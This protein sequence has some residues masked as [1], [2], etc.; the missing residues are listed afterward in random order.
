M[1]N[2]GSSLEDMTDEEIHSTIKLNKRT[3]YSGETLKRLLITPHAKYHEIFYFLS[4]SNRT[5]QYDSYLESYLHKNR[6][7][8]DDEALCYISEGIRLQVEAGYVDF[9]LI[10]HHF[11]TEKAFNE[12]NAQMLLIY[13]MEIGCY[14]IRE[15]L[16]TQNIIERVGRMRGDT[17]ETRKFM[18]KF[19]AALI[20]MNN[21]II[22]EYVLANEVVF[23][24]K[25]KEK[26]LWFIEGVAANSVLKDHVQLDIA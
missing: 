2:F 14:K 18:A 10:I 21:K 6:D 17:F 1:E 24:L 25:I 7:N 16:I 13:L 19:V 9:Y 22:V 23:K 4:V 26:I 8:F 5:I 20:A 12:P 11:Y 3:K 15:F